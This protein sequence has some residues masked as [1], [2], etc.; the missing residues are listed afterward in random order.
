ML[1]AN[2]HEIFS[3]GQAGVKMNSPMFLEFSQHLGS[4]NPVVHWSLICCL[5]ANFYEAYLLF[6][7]LND[8]YKRIPELQLQPR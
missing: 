3:R 4:W 8:V 7:T 5:S 2:K 6:L 1:P